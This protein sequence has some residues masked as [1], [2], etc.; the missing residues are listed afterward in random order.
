M[1]TNSI[2]PTTHVCRYW[3]YSIIST[4]ENWTR[5]SGE[6][7]GLAKLS[8]QRC[9]STPLKVWVGIR[10]DKVT[11]EFF[12][13]MAPHIRNTKALNVGSGLDPKEFTPTLR[14]IFPLTPNLRSLSLVRGPWRPLLGQTND[15]CDQLTSPLTDL[16]LSDIPLYPSLMRLR[17]LTSF[18]IDNYQ[19]N[20]PLDTLLDFLGEN[21]SL[22][23]AALG[24]TFTQ[25]SLRTSRPRV[26]IKNRL[27][28]LVIAS[29]CATDIIVL[30]SKIAIQTGAH[31][32]AGL[33][34]P[35]GGS[36]FIRPVVSAT[37]LMNLRSPTFLKYCP[38]KMGMRNI[39]LLGPNGSCSL[40][41]Q[42]GSAA[43]FVEFPLLPLDVIQT[44]QLKHRVS[45]FSHSG[46]T[47]T[48]FPPLFFPA[49]E[50]LII[51]HET[52]MSFLLS[53]FFSNPS[54]SPSLKTFAFLDCHLD[55]GF[56]KKLTRFA[57]H[58]QKIPANL[59]RVV[60]INSTGKLPPSA[61]IDGLRKCVTVVDVHVG[62]E[63]PSD[64]K[65]NSVVG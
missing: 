17:S 21:R 10:Q 54:S 26:P 13:L 9:K 16:F 15:P 34:K 8:L 61:S 19:F 14:K 7:I 23:Q 36:E 49:L 33:S 44:V 18:T 12:D 65:W 5:I 43:V 25:P 32:T 24:I 27:R 52:A 38:D 11:R 59:H 55:K 39:R 46:Q 41:R 45:I 64:L 58:R 40:K 3:R 48:V 1:D 37:H 62:K 29:D 22:E 20:L 28:R 35:D 47:R 4:P 42:S 6:R 50:T 30:A 31:L 57:S 60:V 63:L 53:D 56:M 2:I 51:E